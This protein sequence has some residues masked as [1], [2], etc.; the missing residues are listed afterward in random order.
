MKPATLTTEFIDGNRI[1]VLDCKHATTRAALIG[2]PGEAPPIGEA[3][4][5]SMVLFRHYEAEGCDC[6]AE[7]R[8]RYG[9]A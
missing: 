7:L 2:P 1:L 9:G 6:T 3:I 4:M 5:V 8:R